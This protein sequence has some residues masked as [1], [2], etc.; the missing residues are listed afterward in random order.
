MGETHSLPSPPS[1]SPLSSSLLSVEEQQ[2]H[3]TEEHVLHSLPS[4]DQLPEHEP[5]E[6]DLE[7]LVS[8][9]EPLEEEPDEDEPENRALALA[10]A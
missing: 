4:D 9:S 10:R 5:D 7:Q 1:L 8:V 3:D 2:E 6:E